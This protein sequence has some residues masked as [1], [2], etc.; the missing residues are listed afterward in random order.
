MTCRY[1]NHNQSAP[2]KTVLHFLL[3]RSGVVNLDRAEQVIEVSE[4]ID[5]VEPLAN[6]TSILANLT[7]NGTVGDLNGAD[8]NVTKLLI[9]E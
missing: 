4:W 9:D 2:M 8:F 7:A 6:L 3:D 5:V 1:K